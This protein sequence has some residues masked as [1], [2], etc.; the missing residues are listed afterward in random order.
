MSA[1][2]GERNRI[3]ALTKG[4]AA[5]SVVATHEEAK[6]LLDEMVLTGGSK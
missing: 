5:V 3:L 4:F 6:A 2:P 1:N